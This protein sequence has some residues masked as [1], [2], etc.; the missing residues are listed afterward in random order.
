[1]G[2][3]HAINWKEPWLMGLMAFHVL[4]LIAVIFSRK[5]VNFQMCLFLMACKSNLRMLVSS[6]S[7]VLSNFY[8]AVCLGTL[9]ICSLYHAKVGIVKPKGQT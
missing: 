4:L 8:H 7:A 5:N 3:F 1:M 9:F 6:L 2:F